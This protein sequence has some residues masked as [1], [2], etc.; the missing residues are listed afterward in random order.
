[1]V[2]PYN[3]VKLQDKSW[4]Q[5]TDLFEQP[6][7]PHATIKSIEVLSADWQGELVFDDELGAGFEAGE[8]SEG[9][10]GHA[11]VW[12]DTEHG[13]F[14]NGFGN[15]GIYLPGDSDNVFG[16]H[17]IGECDGLEVAS[18]LPA[19][20]DAGLAEYWIVPTFAVRDQDGVVNDCFNWN[21]LNDKLT[22]EV[23][24]IVNRIYADRG[25]FVWW[26]DGGLITKYLVSGCVVQNPLQDHGSDKQ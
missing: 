13:L 9:I 12:A 18:G 24:G 2:Y 20:A 19:E 3:R 25:V 1:M 17:E 15:A 4:L 23:N 26:D 16:P 6:A 11:N 7:K 10:K 8:C 22:G 21:G 5:K 14:W